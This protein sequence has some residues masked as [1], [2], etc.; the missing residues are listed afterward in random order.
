MVFNLRPR[1]I[2][3]DLRWKQEP[4]EKISGLHELK[5][6][7]WRILALL[8]IDLLEWKPHRLRLAQLQDP[9]EIKPFVTNNRTLYCLVNVKVALITSF[10]WKHITLGF[11]FVFTPESSPETS[12][13]LSG[14]WGHVLSGCFTKAGPC[15]QRPFRSMS[16]T[17]IL[18]DVSSTEFNA[19]LTYLHCTAEEW[20]NI[21]ETRL[22]TKTWTSCP[23]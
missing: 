18:L 3:S 11:K 17:F 8:F 13:R 12:P 19:V 7:V 15:F 23:C 4:A 10:V 14:L 20:S 9:F 5:R 1:T 2:D 22:E 16:S 21:T 6:S